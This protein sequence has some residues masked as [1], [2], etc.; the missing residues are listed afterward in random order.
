LIFL[1]FLPT[2]VNYIYIVIMFDMKERIKQILED[3]NLTQAAFADLIGV[4]RPSITHLMTGRNKFSQ[5]VASNTLLAFPDINPLWLVKGEGEI[6]NNSYVK[7]MRESVSADNENTPAVST[8]SNTQYSE[9]ISEEKDDLV[10]P[11]SN[12]ALNIP[13]ENPHTN[14]ICKSETDIDSKIITQ[15]NDNKKFTENRHKIEKIV[16]FYNDQ[17]FEEYYP[18]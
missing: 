6:Y 12:Q 1:L 13:D 5:V 16:F 2:N 14:Q 7:K 3:K 18:K 10:T 15:N 8:F 17:T 9:N 11:I 4:G